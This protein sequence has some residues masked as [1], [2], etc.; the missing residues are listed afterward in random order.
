VR[1]EGVSPTIVLTQYDNVNRKWRRVGEEQRRVIVRRKRAGHLDVRF[2]RQIENGR[3]AFRCVY[4]LLLLLRDPYLTERRSAL[5]AASL[6]LFS[7][8]RSLPDMP[9]S[10]Y[11]TSRIA[12]DLFPQCF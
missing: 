9:A 1:A 4:F 5:L 2:Q 6:S 11:N 7:F 10:L 8:S 3:D 12:A